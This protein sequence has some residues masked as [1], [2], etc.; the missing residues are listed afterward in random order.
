MVKLRSK[1]FMMITVAG[2]AALSVGSVAFASWVLGQ[3]TYTQSMD[4]V[5]V[6]VG[7]VTDTRLTV[8]VE[9][10]DSTVAFDSDGSQAEGTIGAL[11]SLH[12]DKD[13]MSF[14][15]TITIVASDTTVAPSSIIKNV[16]FTLNGIS[17]FVTP[18]YIVSPFTN[19][20]ATE[21]YTGGQTPS[22]KTIEGVTITPTETNSNSE[23]ENPASYTLAIQV[24]VTFSW[25]ATFDSKNPSAC[26]ANDTYIAAL[27]AFDALEA[28]TLTG[29]V[30]VNTTQSA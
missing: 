6:T 22:A 11:D 23:T 4:N 15:F 30:T 29:T 27:K 5:S 18:G 19:G 10:N 20:K 16:Q 26:T 24:A 7:S 8:S 2:L 13:D 17:S 9:M 28:P 12:E 1:K 3:E 21:I 25:G 14:S